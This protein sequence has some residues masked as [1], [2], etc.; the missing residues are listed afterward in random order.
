MANAL[1]LGIGGVGSVIGLKLHEWDCF[2]KIH[3]ADID[4]S[5]ATVKRSRSG[6]T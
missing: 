6:A 2:E 5:F 3:L 4:T 1:V